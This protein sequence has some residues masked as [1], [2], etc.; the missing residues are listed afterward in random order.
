MQ[1]TLFLE[2]GLSDNHFA[3]E[4][5]CVIRER[6]QLALLLS[7][8]QLLPLVV[9]VVI[10]GVLV[11]VPAEHHVRIC[12]HHVL[13]IEVIHL[14]STVDDLDLLLLVGLVRARVRVLS[15]QAVLDHA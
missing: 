12:G 9:V 5:G 15:L 1:S 11:D 10:A 6:G 3:L 13:A 7:L 14:S 8:Q 4:H 2:Y